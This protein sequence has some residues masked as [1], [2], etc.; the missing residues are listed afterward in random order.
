MRAYGGRQDL[1]RQTDVQSPLSP[2][3]TVLTKDVVA[4]TL[5]RINRP[6]EILDSPRSKSSRWPGDDADLQLPNWSVLLH[7]EIYRQEMETK[8]EITRRYNAYLKKPLRVATGGKDEA[9]AN[10]GDPKGDDDGEPVLAIDDGAGG[11]VVAE[12]NGTAAADEGGSPTAGAASPA[13]PPR[14]RSLSKGK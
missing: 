6:H 10:S 13:K 3:R 12:G 8:A 11:E 5:R 4:A 14:R 7:D 2:T 1:A 9:G